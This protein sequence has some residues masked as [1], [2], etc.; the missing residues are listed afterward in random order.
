MTMP[1]RRERLVRQG[2]FHQFVAADNY[3]N[4]KDVGLN[5]FAVGASLATRL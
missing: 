5:G 4:I 3:C 2:R 1:H